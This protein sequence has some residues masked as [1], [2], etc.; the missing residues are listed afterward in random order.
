MSPKTTASR[1]FSKDRDNLRRHAGE[2]YKL[3]RKLPTPARAFVTVM[4]EQIY[5]IQ[6]EGDLNRL[7]PY[8]RYERQRLQET[9]RSLT[10]PIERPK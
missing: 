10:P 4:I 2:L 6:D 7:A 9:L 8:M 3:R 1:N 5:Q